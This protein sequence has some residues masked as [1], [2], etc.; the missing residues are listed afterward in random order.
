LKVAEQCLKRQGKFQ[1]DTARSAEEAMEMMEKETYDA[2]VSDYQMPGKDGLQFLKELRQ[3]GDNIPFIIF[4]GKG[5]EEVVIKALNLGAD[6]YEN[7]NGDPETVYSELSHDIINAVRTRRAEQ[8]L[9]IQREELQVILDSMPA[10]I[11]YKDRNNRLVRVNKAFAEYMGVSKVNLEGK[12]LCD[13]FPPDIAQKCWEEDKEVIATGQPKTDI[14]DRHESA[15]GV[16]WFSTGKVPC[17]EKDGNIIGTINFSVDI[18]ERKQAEEALLAQRDRLETVTRNIG[19]GL[20]IISKDYRTLWANDVLKRIFGDVE[21]KIC[22]STYNQR[23]GICPECGVQE[24]FE[25]GKAKVVHEQVGKDVDGKTVWS[26]ITATPVKDRD[27]NV[28]AVLE[29]VVPITQR[30]RAE[31]ELRDSEGKYGKLF[32]EAMDAIFVADAETGILIDCN[33]AASEL[34]GREKSELIGKHQ[35][36]L[37]PPEKTVEEFS[38]TFKQHLKEKEGR[39]LE[40]QVITKK[41]EI[42][43][44]AVKANVFELGNKRVVQGIF[45]DI[46]GHA[47]ASSFPERN[48][49]P[50]LEVD[51]DGNTNYLNP[52]AQKLLSQL[53]GL[54]LSNAFEKELKTLVDE[55]KIHRKGN[56]VCENFKIGDRYYQQSIYYFSEKNVLRLYMIDVTERKKAEEALRNS[57]GRWRSLAEGSPD[58]IMLLDLKGNILYINR[59]VPDLKREEVIGTSQFNYVPPE[60]HRVAKDCFKRVIETGKTDHYDTEYR[61]IDGE[62]RYFD[63]RIGPVRQEDRVVALISSSTDVTSQKKAGEKIRESEQKFRCLV[64]E[65]AAYVGI[66]DLKGQFTY[67]NEALADSLGYSVQEL[68]GRPFKDFLHPD[69]RGKIVRLFLKSILLRRKPQS[70]EFRVIRKDGHVLHWMAK[71]TAF[72]IEGKTV[73]FQAIITDITE[74]KKAERT[75]KESE[76]KYRSLVE[77]APDGIVAVNTEGIVTS[78]NHSFLTLVGYD[79]E[80]IVGKPFTELKT[81]RV[82]DIPK[83][84][85]MFKSL[86]KGESPSPVEFLYVRRDGTSRW[87]EVHPSLLVKDGNPVGAQVIM[88][89]VSERKKAEKLIQESQQK[90]EGLFRYNPEAAVCLDLDSKVLD[91][92]P[93]FCELFGYSGKEVEGKRINEVVVPEDMIEEAETLDKDAKKG[94]ASRDTVRKRKDGSLVHVSISATP[95]TTEG[96]L[97]GYVGVYK[98]IT[99]LKNAEERLKEMNKRL[100]V[101]NEKLRVVG[102]LTRHD[103]RNKLS[104]VTGNAYLLRRKL[105]EDPKALEQLSDMETAVRLVGDIFEFAGTYEKL[106]VEQPSYM[107]VGKAVDEAVA[108]FSDLKGVK[109]VNE[110]DGLTVLA[111][112]LLRQLFYNLVDNSLKYGEKIQQIKTYYRTPSTDQLEL[113][114]E[115]DGVGIPN[116]MRSNLFKEGFTSG[117]GTGYGLFMIKRMCEVYGWTIQETGKQGKG[118][119]FTML[120]PRIGSTG[121][122][123]YQ[124]QKPRQH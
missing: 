27:G 114:Y 57:E 88:R 91:V 30:K 72:A 58:H 24:I 102:S 109:V 22:Y 14:L 63:V 25:T 92:N 76:E 98:D 94:Y 34:V 19:A 89:D 18:T 117:K 32:D 15:Q 16:R 107:D 2:I 84:Q 21:G 119:Q 87:A 66:I 111:D 105:A 17:R 7:K 52:A 65:A 39:I 1:V 55:F 13:L 103:V 31:E 10:K 20:A 116:N 59:T 40:T 121:K 110:C 112:S 33:R 75:L 11:W 45:R 26:E 101:T 67:V 97:F 43:E 23:S 108:L 69:D 3:K 81:S 46:T 29:L 120:I 73:G 51:L 37:H 35:R 28:T 86:M 96:K 8:E 36:I 122:V 44:V 71:P 49:N 118:A 61:T 64:E 80:E 12:P 77:L 124:I 48:P 74:R 53:R 93:R 95:V 85:E 113:V 60:W 56:F 106:G 104:A 50:I 38:T 82:E 47:W 4:T 79:S 123:N 6:H 68:T 70:L 5:R 41:G 42:K 78:A 54:K 100:E 9:R 90:F 99:K 115:D 62:V 83:M